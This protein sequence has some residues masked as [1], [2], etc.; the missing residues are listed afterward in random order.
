M[1]KITAQ[2]ARELAGANIQERV[3]EVYLLIRKAAEEKKRSITLHGWPTD[4]GYSGAKEYMQ[5]CKMLESD[6]YKVT[7]FY[8][9]RQF[10]SMY[11]IV[12]W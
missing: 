2:E 6:G 9:E 8:E 4:Q 3:D 5:A 1:S 12:E 7:F 10:V 11:T